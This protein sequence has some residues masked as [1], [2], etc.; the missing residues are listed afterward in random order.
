MIRKVI[1]LVF[2][3]LSA[4]QASAQTISLDS[5]RI[6]ALRNNKQMRVS[7][8]NR[9]LTLNLRKA[10]RTAYLPKVDVLGSYQHFGK[11]FSAMDRA[12]KNSLNNLG[13][14]MLSGGIG[15]V[16]DII[17]SLTQQGV[18][19]PAMAQ[20]IGSLL[21]NYSGNIVA[22]FNSLGQDIV[23]AF[24]T[25]TKNVWTG[26]VVVRQ[27]VYMGGAIVAANKMADIGEQFA[28][29]QQEFTRQTT[30]YDIDRAYWMVVSLKQ[31]EK[32]AYSY[33][34]L[35]KKLDND[36][37]KMI[38]Q[39]VATKSDGL[40]VDVAVNSADLK[41]TQVED[42]V[43]LAKMLLCQLTG[44]PLESKITLADENKEHLDD[45]YYQDMD[46]QT[47]LDN[48]PEVR[49]LQNAVDISKQ[50]TN[51]VRA[52]FLPHVLLTGGYLFSN[53]NPFNGIDREFG[54]TW[55]VGVTLQMNVW[56]WFEGA[57][58]TRAT[59]AATLM[60]ELER[61]DLKQ[62]MQLEVEQDR[63]KLKE[64]RKRLVMAENNLKSANENLRS[65][66][67]GFKEG[68]MNSTDVM[69][70]QTAWQQAQSAKID[71][72]VD[73]KLSQSALSKALGILN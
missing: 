27:P 48:R 4:L 50:N 20:Q 38:N 31:K 2:A 67:V 55:N 41:I 65:A 70:A 12:Q 54:S 39:G 42:G 34:D 5:C 3:V 21:Q 10:A 63:F 15:K 33:R 22:P 59:K 26:A 24:R 16:T 60:A 19:T 9:D 66:N 13:T 17:T 11:E 52:Q 51:L 46:T 71:A 32:L 57:Y 56:N 1:I 23:D 7:L 30:L 45:T 73:V 69:N 53:P 64:A 72:E 62:K 14:N 29:N 43:V 68:V 49:M 37:K 18:F 6:M 28:E 40:K 44:L 36:V 8:I 58:K 47:A 61:D 35:V 25:D